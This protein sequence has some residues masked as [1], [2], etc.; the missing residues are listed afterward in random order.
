M[1][2]L[3]A[4]I[5]F[6]LS[7]HSGRTA[8]WNGGGRGGGASCFCIKCFLLLCSFSFPKRDSLR[9]VVRGQAPRHDHV[10]F[11]IYTKSLA[12]AVMEVFFF[13][14]DSVIE[15]FPGGLCF[16]VCLLLFSPSDT[17]LFATREAL[18]LLA[19]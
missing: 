19:P 2:A 10:S 15:W 12:V 8:G 7:G 16:L 5:A 4:E 18:N 6:C 14:N 1:P 11:V 13:F 3:P 9:P 17:H